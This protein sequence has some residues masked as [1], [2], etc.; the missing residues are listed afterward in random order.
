MLS[1]RISQHVA[2]DPAV[3]SI[4]SPLQDVN[5]CHTEDKCEIN[6]N[7]TTQN[8]RIRMRGWN[9]RRG[10]SEGHRQ[11]NNYANSPPLCLT[12]NNTA[13]YIC[14]DWQDAVHTALLSAPSHARAVTPDGWPLS[15]ARLL[16]QPSHFIQTDKHKQ[17]PKLSHVARVA[18][19]GSSAAGRQD[20]DR[21]LLLRKLETRQRL[22]DLISA[23][24]INPAE[25]KS[26]WL[27]L[28]IYSAVGDLDTTKESWW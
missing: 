12:S 26:T 8:N 28:W 4:T 1:E 25:V 7:F 17:R 5:S 15:A 3:S 20:G 24:F 2:A 27:A 18:R 19:Q 14:K 10:A 9:V 22:K 23:G 21:P 16:G 11:R 6:L 13:L